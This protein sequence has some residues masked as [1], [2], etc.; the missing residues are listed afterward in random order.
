LERVNESG[1]TIPGIANVLFDMK[2]LKKQFFNTNTNLAFSTGSCGW[3][4]VDVRETLGLAQHHG[5][6]TRL[7][8]WTRNP[9][10]AAHFAALDVVKKGWRASEGKYFSI[11]AMPRRM[12]DAVEG[13]LQTSPVQLSVVHVPRAG[14]PY[15]HAQEGLFLLF[16]ALQPPAPPCGSFPDPCAAF[17]IRGLDELIDD[18]AG[19]EG[20]PPT[21]EPTPWLVRLDMPWDLAPELLEALFAQGVHPGRLMPGYDGAARAAMESRYFPG[22]MTTVTGPVTAKVT[23]TVP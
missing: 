18:L 11:W 15:L 5:V 14:N 1:L 10:I 19:R 17:Q 20:N 8:D 13:I 6:A 4:D 16:S 9:A 22:G 12:A 21:A 3:P 2:K 7:L 23:A